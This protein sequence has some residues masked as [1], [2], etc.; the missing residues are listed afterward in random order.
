[1]DVL[2]ILVLLIALVLIALIVAVV[3]VSVQALAS[4]K[5]AKASQAKPSPAAESE[6]TEPAS[7]GSVM[8]LISPP[9]VGPVTTSNDTAAPVDKDEDEI[10]DEEIELDVPPTIEEL[11]SKAGP[12]PVNNEPAEVEPKAESP[13][14]AK[15]P[16]TRSTEE[17]R[18]AAPV[19]PVERATIPEDTLRRPLEEIK[20]ATPARRN[21][22]NYPYMA[23]GPLL[24]PLERLFYGDL[25]TSI[26]DNTEIFCKV[27]ASDILNPRSDLSL[28]DSYFA[29]DQLATQRFDF[30]LCDA[31]DFSVIGVIELDGMGERE[32]L[33]KIQR[34]ILRKSAESANLPVL[35]VDMKRGYTIREIREQVNYLLPRDSGGYEGTIEHEAVDDTPDIYQEEEEITVTL[36][37]NGVS[38]EP[39]SAPDSSVDSGED[40]QET[41][42]V[43]AATEAVA[44]T[45]VSPVAASGNDTSPAPAAETETAHKNVCPRCQSPLKL[46]LATTGEFAGQYFWICTKLPECPYVAPISPPQ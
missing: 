34:E 30:V 33:R 14:P 36:A 6:A 11:L 1:M 45:P 25:K 40:E 37:D 27:R 12:A 21:D 15:Q 35:L 26:S 7:I 28:E 42:A 31:R 23:G 44:E 5:R 9:P 38:E 29:A 4:S 8:D 39:D 46:S 20:L 24:T 10:L 13:A 17:K 32:G 16:D 2:E 3:L 19:A 43:T 41:V 18:P 22:D